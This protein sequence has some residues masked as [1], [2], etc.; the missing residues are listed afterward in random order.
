MKEQDYTIKKIDSNEYGAN[1]K[2]EIRIPMS[3]G[4]IDD[5]YFYT[6]YEL[7]DCQIK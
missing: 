2:I 7:K 3:A 4:W 5:V 1:Y 6:V